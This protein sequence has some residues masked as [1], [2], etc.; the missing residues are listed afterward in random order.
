M[1]AYKFLKM[2]VHAEEV[3]G[4]ILDSNDVTVFVRLGLDASENYYEYEVPLKP[5]DPS[6]QP[7]DKS[8][9]SYDFAYRK[10]CGLS[11]TR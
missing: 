11:R 2:W 5:S 1:R 7:T 4:Q 6:I 8:N 3:T 9:P 10:T